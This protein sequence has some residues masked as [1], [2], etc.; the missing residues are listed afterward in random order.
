M[1]NYFDCE[2]ALPKENVAV[3]AGEL[4]LLVLLPKALDAGPLANGDA[5]GV[6]EPPKLKAPPLEGPPKALAVVVAGFAAVGVPIGVVVPPKENVGFAAPSD[7]SAGADVAPK[8]F[9]VFEPNIAPEVPDAPKT[10]PPNGLDVPLGVKDDNEPLLVVLEPKPGVLLNA[11]RPPL[12]PK[13]DVALGASPVED[14]L[15]ASLVLFV[16]PNELAP[17]VPN[18]PKEEVVVDEAFP[19]NGLG[20]DVFPNPPNADGGF[21]PLVPPKLKLGTFALLALS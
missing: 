16:V 5:A 13:I 12:A 11:D 7:F 6:V 2:G 4:A 3:D 14:V 19:P 9:V 15:L 18:P 10:P 17:G 20:A 21:V 8:D 1:W